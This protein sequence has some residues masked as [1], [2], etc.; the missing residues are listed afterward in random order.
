MK[1]T[2]IVAGLAVV[3]LAGTP[4]H[5]QDSYR[6]D[7]PD[8]LAKRAKIT[9]VV[10]AATAQQRVPKGKIDGVEL[11]NEKNRLI[12]SYD[13]KT[14]GKSGIDEVNVDAMTGKIIAFVHESPAAEKK[15]AADDAKAAKKTPTAAKPKKP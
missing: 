10:A 4:A 3:V 7:V 12:Y 8:S 14:A 13:I 6:R 11:E 5:A 1:H 2:Y 9:E 15:E